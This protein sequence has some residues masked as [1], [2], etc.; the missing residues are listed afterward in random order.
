MEVCGISPHRIDK[1]RAR[2]VVAAVD[3]ESASCAW[4]LMISGRALKAFRN[5]FYGAAPWRINHK[6]GGRA[7][8]CSS[9]IY[10]GLTW[11]NRPALSLSLCYCEVTETNQAQ[12]N[13]ARS[14][15]NVKCQITKG[16]GEKESERVGSG[17]RL[18]V[19]VHCEGR[20]VRINAIPLVNLIK[21]LD[22]RHARQPGS[23]LPQPEVP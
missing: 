11:I 5:R 8:R 3:E 13:A 22:S 16:K 12:N 18:S 15:W 14:T 6:W 19:I 4:K 21:T 20:L 1:N 9:Y 7:G 23:S 10:V 17:R 2:I